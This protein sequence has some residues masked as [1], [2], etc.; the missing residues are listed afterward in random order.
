MERLKTFLTVALILFSTSVYA[1][2]S[3]KSIKQPLKT[4]T[5]QTLKQCPGSSVISG[6]RYTNIKR[7]RKLS[8]HASGNAVDIRGNPSCVWNRIKGWKGGASTDY[9]NAPLHY[10][11]SWGG[12]EHGL[13][14]KHK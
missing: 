6:V 9:K 14:F 3:L 7:S 5:Q 4:W 2:S 11:V 10:H 8:L 13:R 1:D 12:S